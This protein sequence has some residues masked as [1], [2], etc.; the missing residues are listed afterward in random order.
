[1]AEYLNSIPTL[2]LKDLPKRERDQYFNFLLE[3]EVQFVEDEEGYFVA[4]I[5][6]V[7]PKLPGLETSN[8]KSPIRAMQATFSFRQKTVAVDSPRT[9]RSVSFS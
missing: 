3:N 2:V 1:M 8:S 7:N 4:V 9:T 6:V 5:K